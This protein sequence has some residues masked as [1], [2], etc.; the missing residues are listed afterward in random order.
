MTSHGSPEPTLG[1]Q[2]IASSSR[3]DSL[4]RSSPSPARS[5]ERSDNGAKQQTSK[6]VS[7]IRDQAIEKYMGL[8]R[9]KRELLRKNQKIQTKISQH[10]RKNKIELSTSS[11]VVMTEE[12]ERAEYA[13]LLQELADVMETMDRE[14]NEFE[15]E[16]TD[17]QGRKRKTDRDIH[18]L[19]NELESLRSKVLK[20]AKDS[21]TGSTIGMETVHEI[22]KKLAN[23]ESELRLLRLNQIRNK[24]KLKKQETIHKPMIVDNKTAKREELNLENKVYSDKL[25]DSED[26]MASLRHAIAGDVVMLSHLAM[27]LYYVR[28]DT[29]Q[30]DAED[31][32]L[33]TRMEDLKMEIIK[34]KRENM[35]LQEE[36][37][38]LGEK[39]G[40]IANTELL[41]DF[42]LTEVECDKKNEDNIKLLS[43]IKHFYDM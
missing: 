43:K 30:L 16:M 24:L 40:M 39:A 19:E 8:T 36:K 14:N 12:D 11:G 31:T 6:Q 13:R 23:K 4:V 15:Q 20:S 2:L 35:D 38:T 28:M 1:N 17:V 32:H 37:E 25:E 3:G 42:K 7:S 22:N 34:L 18:K 9:H 5:R 26:K 33:N 21:Q 41:G 29:E 10:L 27:K